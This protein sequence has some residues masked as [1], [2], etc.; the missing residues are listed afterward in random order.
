MQSIVLALA[1]LTPC[2][3][4]AYSRP[5]FVY[6]PIVV[7]LPGYPPAFA[8]YYRSFALPPVYRHGY[9]VPSYRYNRP[10]HGS[11]PS[12]RSPFTDKSYHKH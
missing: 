4:H 11:V 2:T 6:P 10:Y 1:L 9:G 7:Q 5:Y 12:I 3:N 8:P